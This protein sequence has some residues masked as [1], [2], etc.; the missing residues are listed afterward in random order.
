MSEIQSKKLR[1]NV[2]FRQKKL[3]IID[4]KVNECRGGLR[5]TVFPHS[6]ASYHQ[7][8]LPPGECI[9]N[10]MQW[11]P[12]HTVII[13][14]IYLNDCLTINLNSTLELENSTAVKLTHQTRDV[15]PML[16]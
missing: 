5:D 15:D 8:L 16:D 3:L 2:T 9:V 7:R 10:H 6:M 14:S 13:F 12:V 11:L 1:G 4:P